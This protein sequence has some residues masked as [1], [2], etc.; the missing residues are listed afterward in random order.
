MEEDKTVESIELKSGLP[1]AVPAAPVSLKGAAQLQKLMGQ[2]RQKQ[3]RDKINSALDRNKFS[4]RFELIEKIGQGGMG[5]VYKA[6]D[7]ELSRTVAIKLLTVDSGADSVARDRFLREG[8]AAALLDHR[9][10]VKIHS[11]GITEEGNPYHIMELLNGDSL[12]DLLQLGPL[13]VSTFWE[14]MSAVL[15]GLAHLH[16]HGI[17]HRDLKPSNIVL[18]QALDGTIVPKIIDFGIVRLLEKSQTDATLTRTNVAVGSPKYMSP[19]QCRGVQ[20]D[21]RT[22]IYALGC[23]M[24]ECLSG[25]V[26]FVAESPLDLMYKQLT[27]EPEPLLFAGAGGAELSK[28]ILRCLEKDPDKRPQTALELKEELAQTIGSEDLTI[29]HSSSGAKRIPTWFFASLAAL[30][31]VLCVAFLSRKQDPDKVI[32]KPDKREGAMDSKGTLARLERTVEMDMHFIAGNEKLD[33]KIAHAR[34]ISKVIPHLARLFEEEKAFD[35]MDQFFGKYEQSLNSILKQIAKEKQPDMEEQRRLVG[36]SRQ[37]L[38]MYR[39]HFHEDHNRTEDANDDFIKAREYVI[40]VWQK[41]SRQDTGVLQ[42]HILLLL[43]QDK[44][45]EALKLLDECFQN[46]DSYNYHPGSERMM[47]FVTRGEAN[48]E[49]ELGTAPPR[50][51]DIVLTIYGKTSEQFSSQAQAYIRVLLKA[52]E[53]F[54]KAALPQEAAQVLERVRGYLKGNN[55]LTDGERRD[56][57]KE[58]ERVGKISPAETP[59]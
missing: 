49:K 51:R 46:W 19:E 9:N 12:Q 20:V 8:K 29:K 52:A 56:L 38:L 50:L 53:G 34:E 16:E 47:N 43:R 45:G 1:T 18:S 13:N 33:E 40:E 31:L 25:S 11:S 59:P 57:E 35:R 30:V 5:V 36:V 10:V 27:D 48:E 23:I 26:P 54:R 28:V 2:V 32:R 14:V 55:G 44:P 17:V 6:T 3:K 24:Y 41:G 39:G 15:D 7:V 22:D 37:S 4:E 21:Q 58:I 42:S